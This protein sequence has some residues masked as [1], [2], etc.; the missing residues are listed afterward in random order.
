MPNIDWKE[1]MIKYF[2]L[3]NRFEIECTSDN[4]TTLNE[5][6]TTKQI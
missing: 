1:H 4:T 5:H 3:R 6:I 2:C